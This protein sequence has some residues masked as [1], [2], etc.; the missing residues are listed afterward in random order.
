MSQRSYLG[1]QLLSR[2]IWCHNLICEAAAFLGFYVLSCT[3]LSMVLKKRLLRGS[4][5]LSRKLYSVRGRMKEPV[6]SSVLVQATQLHTRA[7]IGVPGEP[8][9]ERTPQTTVE[10]IM[11]ATVN[12][13]RQSK[14]YSVVIQ[15]SNVE[16]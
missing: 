16:G 12:R 10:Y 9:Q 13:A 1:K 14:P 7:R 6:A 4:K 11:E 15:D 8:S 5:A 3:V 2:R